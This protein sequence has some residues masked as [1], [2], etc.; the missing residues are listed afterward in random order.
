MEEQELKKKRL[1]MNLYQSLNSMEFA[2]NTLKEVCESRLSIADN[3]DLDNPD[4][5]LEL[6]T[7]ISIHLKYFKLSTSNVR[8]DLKKYRAFEQSQNSVLTAK[9]KDNKLIEEKQLLVLGQTQNNQVTAQEKTDKSIA[10]KKP[11]VSESVHNIKIES[12]E[13]RISRLEIMIGTLIGLLIGFFII[14]WLKI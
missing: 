12:L 7:P 9:E 2:F 5:Y 11:L 13:K 14:S 4:T 8:D 3:F 1:F 10:D 6:I